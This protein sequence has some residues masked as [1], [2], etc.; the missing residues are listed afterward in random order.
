MKA[1][2]QVINDSPNCEYYGAH[3]R[4]LQKLVGKHDRYRK[5]K[6]HEMYFSMTQRVQSRCSFRDDLF[7]MVEKDLAQAWKKVTT[8]NADEEFSNMKGKGRGKGKGPTTGSSRGIPG[9][10][11]QRA[12]S[13]GL[14]Q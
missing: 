5:R 4:P 10:F 12:P 9:L 14:P 11:V 1:F 3:A 8:K 2:L 6:P 7:A 13:E